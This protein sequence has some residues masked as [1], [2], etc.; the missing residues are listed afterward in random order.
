M[1]ESLDKQKEQADA[2]GRGC[3]DCYEVGDQVLLNAKNLP[4]KL[5]SAVFKT[6]LRPRFVGPFTV[7]A[8]KGLAYTLNLPHKLRTD[9]VFY[10]G[11]LKPYRDP[12]LVDLE[13]LAPRKLALPQAA[14][15]GSTCQVDPAPGS[16]EVPTPARG[17][18]QTLVRRTNES[19]SHQTDVGFEPQSHGDSSAHGA[20]RRGLPPIHRPAIVQSP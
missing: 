11:L 14:T 8:K 2:N 20:P 17:I 12:S 15:S 19:V 9:P 16:A 6:K 5:V 1:A 4:T 10:V 18:G 7:V 13:S 3:I